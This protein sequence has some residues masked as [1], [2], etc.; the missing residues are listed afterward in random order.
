MVANL[1]RLEKIDPRLVWDHEALSFTP[2]LSQGENLALLGQTLELNI[3]LEA[4]EQPVGPFRADLL[5]KET[6]T[7]RWVLIENQL[8]R[9]DHVHLGQLLTYAAGLDAVTIVWISPRFTDEHRACLDWLNRITAEGV[10][11][12][13]VELELWRIGPSA[14][15]P[16]FSVV[17][18]PNDWVKGIHAATQSSQSESGNL[19]FRY[20]SAFRETL[21]AKGGAL[22]PTKALAQNWMTFSPF[23]RTG[24]TLVAWARPHKN[25]VEVSLYINGPEADG[26]YRALRL[27]QAQIEAALGPVTWQAEAKKDRQVGLALDAADPKKEEDWARQ[28]DWLAETLER[29][30][31]TLAGLVRDLQPLPPETLVVQVP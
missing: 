14:M 17:S 12:F 30:R 10:N 31:M 18:K 27:Q 26:F 13:G 24:F 5:C 9:T 21:L 25:R 15:A 22:R 6:N 29:F 28:Q 16:R 20:W 23:G 7:G 11:F 8:E 3:E 1:G 2:W 4:Q 19:Y